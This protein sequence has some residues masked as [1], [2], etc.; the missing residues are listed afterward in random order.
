MSA[1]GWLERMLNSVADHGME[2]IGLKERGNHD[3]SDSEL[4]HR[5][6]D[7][8][9]EASNI[10]L[11]REILQRW[12][13]M[14]SEQRLTFLQMI[15]VEFDPDP[16]EIQ[17]AAQ[18]YQ[19]R[20]PDSLKRLLDISEPPRQELFRRLNMAPGATAILVTMRAELLQILR[21][22][23]ELKGVDYDMRHLLSSWFNR[24][25]LHLERIDWNTS[26]SIL[27][28]LIC[29]EVVHP[30]QGWE[31]LRRRLAEDRR[32]FA[33]FHPALPQDPLIFVEVAL[34]REISD[35][36]TSLVD[37]EEPLTETGSVDTAVFYSINNAL[38]GLRGISFGNFLIKQ[39][40]S[41]LKEEFP[42]LERFVTLSPIP[43]LRNSLLKLQ[44]SNISNISLEDLELVLGSR[45]QQ[46]LDLTG[47]DTPFEALDK[48][49]TEQIQEAENRWLAETL[50]D[51][52]LFY[53]VFLKKGDHAY[54]PVAHFHLSNGARLDRINILANPSEQ[55]IRESWGCMVNYRYEESDL[56]A[57]H[58]TYLCSGHIA[59][60]SELEQRLKH[61]KTVLQRD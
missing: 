14:D 26:A 22:Q 43:R 16:V 47:S 7:G 46:L 3:P 35:S 45:K 57:N 28:K 10:A 20:D 29:Y 24:G 37:P 58:E 38:K 31:D 27:E 5:L 6:V 59:L 32:C 56:V 33:F 36:V 2:L 19:S 41:E 1:L 52:V 30:M 61:L 34:T 11:A 39:V 12:Q 21:Q 9:G 17:Q 55:G 13:E 49:T 42:G 50:N 40:V 60:S 8:M 4:C 53:L 23:P 18:A 51:L 25:F 44:T 48:L 54:E 15:A